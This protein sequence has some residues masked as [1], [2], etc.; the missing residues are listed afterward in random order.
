MNESWL[1]GINLLTSRL[2]KSRLEPEK[3]RDIVCVKLDEIGD[4][5]TAIHV[6]RLLKNY[7]PHARITVLCKPFVGS[8]I[9]SEPSIDSVVYDVNELPQKSQ[10]WIELR[11]TWRTW[12][13]SIFR[14]KGVRLDRGT[15]RFKQRGNQAHERITNFKIIEPLVGSVQWTFDPLTLT[16]EQHQ[17]A[18]NVIKQLKLG[19]FAVFHPGGRSEL[20]HW[21]AERFAGVSE[22][23]YKQFGIKS[24]VIGTESESHIINTIVKNSPES[25]VAWLSKSTL[26][27]FAA[28]ISNA[29]VFLGN[30]SGPLQIA[31]AMGIKSVALFGPG[32]KHVFYP[33]TPGSRVIHNILS[34][35]PC[36]QITCVN[37]EGSCMKLIQEFE[38]TEALT[39]VL[40]E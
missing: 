23:L 18:A 29:R 34:C 11:G 21:P 27:T 12:W 17:E 7:A 9:H 37:P 13:I 15:V 31:D 24:L 1:Y 33:Q 4:M 14:T 26:G 2:W 36:D 19:E 5:V 30:E 32:V 28:L 6:F 25:S 16:D 8:L 38:V 39:A 40:S 3:I 22:F 10:V 20:R 35:N